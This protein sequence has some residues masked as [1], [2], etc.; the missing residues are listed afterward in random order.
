MISRPYEG[1]FPGLSRAR[2]GPADAR[3]LQGIYAFVSRRARPICYEGLMKISIALA[4]LLVSSQARAACVTIG[5]SWRNQAFTAQSAPFTAT[6]SAIPSA[7]R[8]DGVL[9]LSGR[10]VSDYTHLAAILRFNTSGNIDARNGGAYQYKAWVPYSAG[11]TYRFRVS[12]D[13]SSSRYSLWVTPPGSSERQI[14]EN[15]AFRTEQAK[16][17]LFNNVAGRSG[18]GTVQ[19]CDFSAAAAGGVPAPA[20]APAPAPT[21]GCKTGGPSWTNTAITAQTGAFTLTFEGVPGAARIDG[22]FGL[23]QGAVT[24]YTRLATIVRFNNSGTIDARNG[25]TY[26]ALTS[27]PYASG[28]RYKVRALIDLAAKRYSVWVTPPGA[29]ER[30]LASNYAFRTE[31]AAVTRL[32]NWAVKSDGGSLQICNL[33][34][35]AAAPAPTPTPT[36]EPTPTPT[37]AGGDKWGIRKLYP[38]A[39]GGKEWVSK[40]D[41]GSPRSFNGVDPQDAWFD[42]NHGDA[43]YSVTGTGELRI[44]GP[45]PRMYVHDPALQSSWRNVEITVYAKRVADAGTAWGGI[46]CLGRTNHGTTGSETANLC[47]TRGIAARMRYDG[48][49]DFEKETRHPSSKVAASKTFWSGGLPKNVWIGYKH[50]I[51]D[52]ADGNVKQEL[53]LDETDGVGGG[54]WRK[55]NEFIDNGANFGVGGAACKTGI[56]PALRL[57]N[58][59]N[60]PGTESGKPN[61]TVYCRSDDVGTNGLIYKRMSV[62]EISAP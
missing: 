46:V 52:T 13:P 18:G 56:D 23:S 36:P 2:D 26:A 19:L 47:D 1:L 3:S 62:R 14:A 15:Y 39:A 8:I 12:V 4:L 24:D 7:A 44:S 37:P 32:D 6:F 33:A 10:T 31:Q 57:T 42:A 41:N 9:G 40:W 22:V 30:Q 28:Q 61:I 34:T 38:T 35:A 49:I 29:S 53:W 27:V 55:I 25:G 16:T 58:S 59:D 43:S 51:Y 54:N 5:S 21:T 11:V 48:K 17:T 20:P 60:R 50:V 45:V